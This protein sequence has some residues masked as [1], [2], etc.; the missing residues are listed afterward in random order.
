MQGDRPALGESGQH[1][2]FARYSARYL[3]FD[4]LLNLPESGLYGLKADELR[5]SKEQFDKIMKGFMG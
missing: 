1:D 3:L 2:T 4:Q 5:P